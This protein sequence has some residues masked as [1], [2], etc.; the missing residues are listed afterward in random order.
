MSKFLLPYDFSNLAGTNIWTFIVPPCDWLY[1]VHLFWMIGSEQ[2][3]S[4]AVKNA[5]VSLTL[6]INIEPALDAMPWKQALT[7]DEKTRQSQLCDD[8]FST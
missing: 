6:V 5:E 4:G 8:T 7:S 2:F 3:V 1:N